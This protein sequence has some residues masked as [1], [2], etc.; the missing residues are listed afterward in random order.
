MENTSLLVA[1]MPLVNR[2]KNRSGQ[3]LYEC[4]VPVGSSFDC[5]HALGNAVLSDADLSG[6]DLRGA[7]LRGADLSELLKQE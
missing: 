7:D 3:V 5:R 6:A 4:E 2:I 1:G